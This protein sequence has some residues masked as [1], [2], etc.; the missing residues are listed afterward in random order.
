MTRRETTTRQAQITAAAQ[1]GKQHAEPP[2]LDWRTAALRAAGAG[3]LIAAGAIHLDLYLTGYRTIPVIGWLFLLQVIAAFGLGLAVLAT[4]GRPVIAGRL[5]AAGGAGFALATLG[6]YLLSV[7]AGLFGFREVRTTAG[8][9]AGVIEVAAF[10]ALA[11]LALAPAR[12]RVP[13]GGAAAAPARFPAQIPPAIARAAAT[14]AAA[15]AVA[16]LVLLGVAVAGAGPPAPAA[17]SAGTGLKTTVIGGMTVLT[18]ARGFT[19]Y[20]FAPDTP[21]TSKCYGSCAAYWP[22]VTGTAPASP[23]LPGRIGTITRTGGSRQLTYNGHPLYTYIGDTGPGQAKG[24]NLNLN[25][26]LWHEVRVSR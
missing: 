14:T 18:N 12:A 19:L 9:V 2:G 21:T 15:L 10:A 6:G 11:V 22:P 1:A 25:G 23:G 20:S 5:V 3:L 8:V 24:N 17:T 13:A 16:A 4:G 26:G 7:W